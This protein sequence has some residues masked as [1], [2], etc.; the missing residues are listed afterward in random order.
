M[1]D[2]NTVENRHTILVV[3]D[4]R[5]VRAAIK[6]TLTRSYDVIEAEDGEDGWDKLLQNT[7]IKMVISDIMMP[8]LDGYG[9]IC[10]VRAA[11]QSWIKQIPILV[12]TSA[13]DDITRERAHACGAN[14]FVVKPVESSDLL[15]RINFHTEA[16][17][18]SAGQPVSMEQMSVEVEDTVIEAP[19]IDTALD[20]IDG[21]VTGTLDPYA[22]DLALRS[23]FL[24]SYCNKTFKLEM[25]DEIEAIRQKLN[26]F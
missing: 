2:P 22:I 9:F 13:E 4:S 18:S 8:K 24:L 23:L 10:R 5:T 3:D 17:L 15:K 6:K 20:I 14:D 21:K 1:T 16:R 7:H 12:I 19:D 11:E 26:S 25:G